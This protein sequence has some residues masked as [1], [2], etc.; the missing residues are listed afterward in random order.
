M[1]ALAVCVF[2]AEVQDQ[3]AAEQ[4]F[5][6]YGTVRIIFLNFVYFLTE[7]LI[8]S[9]WLFSILP[10]TTPTL[11]PLATPTP[12]VTLPPT[13]PTLPLTPTLATRYA[14]LLI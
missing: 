1:V 4:Y 14:N 12:L 8:M 11:T 7:M 3:E 13:P 2:A 5:L 6:R 10:G 9:Y